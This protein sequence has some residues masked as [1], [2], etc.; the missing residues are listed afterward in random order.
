LQVKAIND[1]T[2]G[3]LESG[4]GKRLEGVVGEAKM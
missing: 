2:Q 1:T 4:N 3:A